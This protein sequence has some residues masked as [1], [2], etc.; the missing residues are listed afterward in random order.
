MI[1]PIAQILSQDNA[2]TAMLGDANN[3]RVFR[4]VAPESTEYPYVI[5]ERIGGEAINHFDCPALDDAVDVHVEIYARS[6]SEAGKVV[7]VVRNALKHHCLV[8]GFPSTGQPTDGT[9]REAFACSW[10]I[11]A[12]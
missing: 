8:T 12:F 3:L 11:E 7:K 1:I 6:E 9:R 10:L 5:W 4:D 2:V